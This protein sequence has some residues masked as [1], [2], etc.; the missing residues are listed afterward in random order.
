M[1]DGR[2]FF[3]QPIQNNIKTYDKIQKIETGQ[4]DDYATGCPLDIAPLSY[5]IIAIDLGKQQALDVDPKATQ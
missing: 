5:K 4:G 2:N 3:D 1:T